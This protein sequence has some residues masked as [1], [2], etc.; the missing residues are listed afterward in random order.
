MDDILEFVGSS[1]GWI[2]GIGIAA[3]AAAGVAGTADG[4]R[5]LAKRAIKGYLALADRA[6]V[7]AA[8]L[9]EQAQDLYA[10]ARMEYDAG[11]AE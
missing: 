5:P 1:A 4:A 11:R 7:A 10:E 2:I 8:I 9:G 6:K 3:G